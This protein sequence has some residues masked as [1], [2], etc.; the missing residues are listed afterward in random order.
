MT[1]R[2]QFQLP[3]EALY[4]TSKI[5]ADFHS[6][7][8]Y[9]IYYFRSGKC[10]Y[11]LGDK[12]YEL[13]PGDLILMNGMTL[14]YP[15][16]DPRFEYC[17]NIVH[18]SSSFALELFRPPY[19]TVGILTP[20]EE[21]RNVPIPLEPGDRERLEPL[22]DRLCLLYERRDSLSHDLFL[23][24][25][26]ELLLLIKEISNKPY[27]KHTFPVSAK[28]ANVQRMISYVES[29]FTEDITLEDL[30]RDLH[31]NKFYMVKLFKETTGITL[32][33]YLYQR[34]INQAKVLFAM[35]PE[36]SV[37]AIAYEVGF[38]HGSHFS[39]TFKKYTGVSPESFRKRVQSNN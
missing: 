2:E 7:L 39:K 21:L 18:F 13:A 38:K 3:I 32:F 5:P 6:H 15:K 31:L 30:A 10:T 29:H 16:V 1:L 25:F 34:R 8:D 17:R 9:E 4:N 36:H 28:Q 37:T 24:G 33:H 22:L 11:L 20:F 35:D 27:A 26:S 14:H 23:S 19:S 12:I